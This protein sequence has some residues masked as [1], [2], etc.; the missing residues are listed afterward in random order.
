M[1]KLVVGILVVLLVATGCGKVPKL[2]NGKEAV[3]EVD[4]GMISVDDLYNEMKNRYALSVL[5]DLIDEKIL[6]TKYES[7]DDEK[8]YIKGRIDQLK[9]Y[10]DYIYKSQYSS[11]ESFIQSQYGTSNESGLNDIFALDYKRGLAIDDYAKSLVTDSEIKDY[12]DKNTVGDIEASHILIT[13]E[14]DE[15]A[16]SEEKTE[17]ENKA[18]ETAKEVIAKLNAGEKFE[19][20]AKT[21]SKDGSSEDGGKLGYFNEGKMAEEFW[22]AVVKLDI[23]EYTKEPVKTQYGYH[24]I[25]KTGQNEKPSLDSVKDTIIEKIATEKKEDDEDFSTKA[26]IQLRK[27]NKMSIVDKDMDTQYENYLYNIGD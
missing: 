25:L 7:N 22:N 24:I 13:A 19:D 1:K 23:N 4:Q 26:L 16:T 9:M 12:Y 3:V 8:A 6:N 5:I 10:Y 20:L 2:E 17:A 21:Y 15:N 27:D 18:L 11:F 14:Y